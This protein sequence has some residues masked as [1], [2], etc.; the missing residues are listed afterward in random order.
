MTSLAFSDLFGHRRGAGA[1]PC[2]CAC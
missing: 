2:R 1:R